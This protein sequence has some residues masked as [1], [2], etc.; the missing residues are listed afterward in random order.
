MLAFINRSGAGE[1]T[2]ISDRHHSHHGRP[3]RLRKIFTL[4]SLP[5]TS[6][7]RNFE[8]MEEVEHN[9]SSICRFFFETPWC[10]KNDVQCQFHSQ[11]YLLFLFLFYFLLNLL[12]LLG[13]D[14]F[15]GF[16]C[17]TNTVR[18]KPCRPCRSDSG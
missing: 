14:I 11:I 10:T 18:E 4:R 6:E 8:A 7:A 1:M 12:D 17:S 5:N 9:L 3:P 2:H 15:V 16:F 13:L